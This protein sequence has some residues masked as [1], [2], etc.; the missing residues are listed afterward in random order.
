M[1]KRTA[2]LNYFRRYFRA[3]ALAGAVFAFGTAGT[4]VFSTPD[5]VAAPPPPIPEEVAT[6]TGEIV[7]HIAPPQSVRAV[8]MSSWVAAT[9]SIRENLVNLVDD[10]EI[11]AIMI[12]IKDATGKI[13]FSVED[14]ELEKFGSVD[15]RIRDIDELLAALHEKG[16]YV[17]GR[18]AVF[19]DQYYASKHPEIAIRRASGELWSDQKGA[20]WIDPA[21]QSFWEYISKIGEE[22]YKRGF[23]EINF[24]YVRYPSE[25]ELSAMVFPVSGDRKKSG[26]IVSFWSY[27][28]GKMKDEGIPSSVDI[29]GMTTTATNDMNIGQVFEDALPNF[30]AISPMTYPSHYPDDYLGFSNP[31]A[32]PYEVMKHAMEAGVS[33]TRA[34]G[35]NISKL[36]PWIQDFDLGIDYGPDEVRAQITALNELGIYSWMLWDPSNVYTKAALKPADGE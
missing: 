8:Y 25:G 33:R 31:A 12:D 22:S 10:T 28:G 13:S 20:L 14:K 17:I 9:P 27:I 24:D 34:A 18:V 30:D 11:N 15:R 32:H 29:F 2:F 1:T 23:D 19:Q 6:S 5:Y 21:A 26:T 16:I 4:S 3:G 36:R 7:R 35:I